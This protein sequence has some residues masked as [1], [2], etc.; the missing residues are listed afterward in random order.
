MTATKVNPP[1]GGYVVSVAMGG[2]VLATPYIL[3]K[4]IL[5]TDLAGAVSAVML[6][7][8]GY[9]VIKSSLEMNA[10]ARRFRS[11]KRQNHQHWYAVS[12]V[13]RVATLGLII[14]V[15]ILDVML[16]N[17]SVVTEVQLIGGTL[18]LFA[19]AST[20]VSLVGDSVVGITS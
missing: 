8:I 4:S 3:V 7:P 18:A 12:L 5:S 6:V 9:I 13:M 16:L 15:A 14:L 2:F 10:K 20:T 11:W 19:V 1:I 17:A